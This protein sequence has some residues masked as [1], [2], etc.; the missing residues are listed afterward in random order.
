M[1]FATPYDE[2]SKRQGKEDA[3]RPRPDVEGVRDWGPSRTRQ[4]DAKEADIN[5]IL[6][7]YA[8]VGVMPIDKFK[9]MRYVNSIGV[10]DYL[11]A[12]NLVQ[13]AQ[14]R[15]DAL[16]AKIRNRFNNNPELLIAFMN[17]ERNYDEAVDLGLVERRVVEPS[18]MAGGPS[19]QGSAAASTGTTTGGAAS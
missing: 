2:E 15:F 10:P 4:A 3:L 1:Q 8:K 7:Q 14:E 12:L 18:A 16:P 17:D 6:A 19:G 11:Q 9:E 5:Y 13:D